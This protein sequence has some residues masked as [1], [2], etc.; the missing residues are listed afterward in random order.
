MQFDSLAATEGELSLAH[1]LV[2]SQFEAL[3][4]ICEAAQD[5]G[6]PPDEPTLERLF[7]NYD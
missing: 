1:R 3:A 2:C 4:D 5:D 7:V 6:P